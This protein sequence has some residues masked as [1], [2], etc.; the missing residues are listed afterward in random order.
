MSMIRD[1]VTSTTHGDFNV[2]TWRNTRMPLQLAAILSVVSH[3]VAALSVMFL[4]ASLV[5]SSSD[6]IVLSSYDSFV[7]DFNPWFMILG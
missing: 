7:S 5:S 4:L 2:N 6:P 1:R 3:A